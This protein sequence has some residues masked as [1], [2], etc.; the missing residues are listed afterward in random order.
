MLFFFDLGKKYSGLSERQ[1]GK[2]WSNYW[3]HGEYDSYSFKV[4]EHSF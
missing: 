1:L 3:E 2:D 4:A